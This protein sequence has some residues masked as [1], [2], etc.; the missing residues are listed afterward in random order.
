M[1]GATTVQYRCWLK[2]NGKPRAVIFRK[3]RLSLSM[4][5]NY[6]QFRAGYGQVTP[7][8]QKAYVAQ[9]TRARLSQAEKVFN[10]Q[11]T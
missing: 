5:S 9:S 2:L 1:R 7:I 3:G 6:R 8:N 4:P 11:T 10:L